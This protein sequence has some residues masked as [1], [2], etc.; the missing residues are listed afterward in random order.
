LSRLQ[1][2]AQIISVQSMRDIA[3]QEAYNTLQFMDEPMAVSIL[4]RHEDY[5]KQE[6]GVDIEQIDVSV[7]DLSPNFDVEPH[8]GALPQKDDLQVMSNLISM[9]VGVEGVAGELVARVDIP[10][11]MMHYIK[12]A[13]FEN[14]HEFMREAQ[15]MPQMQPQ[16]M[17]DDQ[18]AQGVDNGQLVPVGGG[19]D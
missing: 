8:S 14:I 4:G 19:Y 3:W 10:R 13:G 15:Q 16:I 1:R 5:L 2:I 17:P 7:F 9:L 6:F 11:L 18:V 12:K